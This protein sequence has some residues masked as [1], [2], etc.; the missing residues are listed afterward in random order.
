[1]ASGTQR[2]RSELLSPCWDRRLD[3][4]GRVGRHTLRPEDSTR[5]AG[6]P[7]PMSLEIEAGLD[8]VPTEYGAELLAELGQ[9][10]ESGKPAGKVHLVRVSHRRHVT[11]PERVNRFET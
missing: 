4:E 5:D 9:P 10:G 8:R 11:P 7:E 1:M 6:E 3:L 2:R